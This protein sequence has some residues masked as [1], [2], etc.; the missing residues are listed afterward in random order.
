MSPAPPRPLAFPCLLPSSACPLSFAPSLHSD[1]ELPSPH[2]PSS[3]AKDI[4]GAQVSGPEVC[5][6]GGGEASP[7]FP[8]PDP[9]ISKFTGLFLLKKVKTLSSV[10]HFAPHRPTAAPQ[11]AQNVRGWGWGR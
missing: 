6:G 3:S 5:V 10:L 4:R 7:G 8:S 2:I 1:S 9:R 11:E